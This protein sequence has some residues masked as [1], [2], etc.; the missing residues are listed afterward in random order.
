M[1]CDQG[2]GRMVD[3]LIPEDVTAFLLKRIDSITQ[4]EALLWSSIKRSF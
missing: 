2:G 4:L 3:G 1:V